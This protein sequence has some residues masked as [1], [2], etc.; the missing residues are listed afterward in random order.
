[1][2]GRLLEHL[3]AKD[4]PE[5][6][7]AALLADPHLAPFRDWLEQFELRFS[8]VAALLVA[9]WGRRA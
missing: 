3:A 9:K 5:A 4:T 8:E 2:Q 7:R 1:L 6:I